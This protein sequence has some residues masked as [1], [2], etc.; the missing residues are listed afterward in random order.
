MKTVYVQLFL[1]K[2]DS[3]VQ[4][5]VQP[6]LAGSRQSTL[7]IWERQNVSSSSYFYYLVHS[8]DFWNKAPGRDERAGR[9]EVAGTGLTAW[10][11]VPPNRTLGCLATVNL[12]GGTGAEQW[13]PTPATLAGHVA[14]LNI[15]HMFHQKY[16]EINTF[17]WNVGFNFFHLIWVNFLINSMCTFWMNSGRTQ[18][19]KKTNTSKKLGTRR[20][21]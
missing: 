5:P 9:D 1:L 10:Q 17:P 21:R 11:Y 20:W 15:F 19:K 4:H 13:K 2:S 12:Q 6:F 3:Y 16:W 7:Q 8:C 14:N 18:K